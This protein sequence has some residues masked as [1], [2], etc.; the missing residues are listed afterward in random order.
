MTSS[1]SRLS[2]LLLSTC[3]LTPMLALSSD[4]YCDLPSW[5]PTKPF[6]PWFKAWTNVTSGPGG[7]DPNFV[8]N[9]AC[10]WYA[11]CIF[12]LVAE[13]RKQQ[14]GAISIVMALIPLILKDIAWPEQRLVMISSQRNWAVEIVVRGL[15]LNPVIPEDRSR[16]HAGRSFHPVISAAILFFLVVFLLVSY[17]LLAVMEVY[18][19]RSSLGC[20]VPAFVVL[21]FIVGLAP[22]TVEVAI[23]RYRERSARNNTAKL[24]KNG[25]PQNGEAGSGKSTVV[26]SGDEEAQ[27]VRNGYSAVS[28]GG[29]LGGSDGESKHGEN[30]T[31]QVSNNIQ[32]GEQHWVAQFCWGLYYSGGGLIFTSIMLV[33][34]VELFTW[35]LSAGLA[36]AA[37]KMLGYR[38]CGYW[39][40]RVK[41]G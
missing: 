37:G 19:K 38:L 12:G 22:A 30:G 6:S 41:N 29:P 31:P 2:I 24:E 7:D 4:E 40:P 39:G 3:L 10:W 34:V 13:T 15:G 20:P 14:Y 5:N 17:G 1:S 18:S 26:V 16:F 36:S 25:V 35:M 28:T 21:W 9:M 33:T 8:N 27:N 11:D 32:G 23:G